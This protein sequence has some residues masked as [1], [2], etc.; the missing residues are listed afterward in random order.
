HGTELVREVMDRRHAL[1]PR[2]RCLRVAGQLRHV[3]ELASF[4]ILELVVRYEVEVLALAEGDVPQSP[5]RYQ[6]SPSV[7]EAPVPR[8]FGEQIHQPGLR[9]G[10]HDL[11]AVCNRVGGRYLGMDVFAGPQG[12]GG[13]GALLKAA[14]GQRDGVDMR[15]AEYV[16]E[17]FV[18]SYFLRSLEPGDGPRMEGDDRIA[19]GD[20][21]VAVD[22]LEEPEPGIDAPPAQ[23]DQGDPDIAHPKPLLAL[24]GG[25]ER[26]QG[27]APR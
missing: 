7:D 8:L 4:W 27:V 19:E 12:P 18:D 26:P 1:R 13:Q 3:V 15:V 25:D 11:P 2:R 14:H 17:A 24:S 5:L 23:A 9:H 20:D 6:R 21:T 10:A 22:A 16:V